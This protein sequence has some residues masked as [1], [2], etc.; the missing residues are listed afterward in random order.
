VMGSKVASGEVGR[1]VT[2]W[3]HISRKDRLASRVNIL[4]GGGDL[5]LFTVRGVLSEAECLRFVEAAE[6]RGFQQQGS[7]GPKYGEVRLSGGLSDIKT[8]A[9]EQ[10]LHF[11]LSGLVL[12]VTSS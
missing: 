7:R 9:A 5:D 6:L 3:P 4:G 8:A 12:L 2:V 1:D 10:C 11:P